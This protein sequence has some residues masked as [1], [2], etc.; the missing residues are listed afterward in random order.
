[1]GNSRFNDNKSWKFIRKMESSQAI[2]SKNGDLNS[3][4]NIKI[5][6]Q[7]KHQFSQAKNLSPF[8][9]T[10]QYPIMAPYNQSLNYSGQ[11]YKTDEQM[12]LG[13]RMDQ[14]LNFPNIRRPLKRQ[15]LLVPRTEKKFLSDLSISDRDANSK[16]PNFNFI[17]KN[18]K[19]EIKKTARWYKPRHSHPNIRV[20]DLKNAA[21]QVPK[22]F[23]SMRQ[24][25]T[26][27]RRMNCLLYTSPSPRDL[28]TS[29]MPS[30]A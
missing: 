27:M 13:K 21:S 20:L 14:D 4:Y 3:I 11:K 7:Y 15:S 26:I 28:S 30:S 24:A 1:M 16:A 12:F 18:D 22:I 25:I 2:K 8:Q 19:K 10:V 6:N 9:A 17:Q 23:D 5:N 29:R